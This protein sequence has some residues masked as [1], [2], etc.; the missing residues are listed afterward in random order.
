V[1]LLG[2]PDVPEG[3][4]MTAEEWKERVDEVPVSNERE[5]RQ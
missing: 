2:G 3:E 5:E 4:E 1:G